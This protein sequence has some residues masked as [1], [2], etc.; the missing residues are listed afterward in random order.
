MTFL[1]KSCWFLFLRK[2][3]KNQLVF[4]Y[5]IRTIYQWNHGYFYV[6]WRYS[7]MN[8]A[9]FSHF[10]PIIFISGRIL[11]CSSIITIMLTLVVSRILY[12]VILWIM[13]STILPIMIWF[14]FTKAIFLWGFYISDHLWK[15]FTGLWPSID[16]F[17]LFIFNRWFF[18]P[19]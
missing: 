17:N 9:M 11:L 2:S 7:T 4:L 19:R 14:N 8:I 6:R 1:N 5:W 18:H 13:F 12:L 15:R 10:F 3:Q 16:N